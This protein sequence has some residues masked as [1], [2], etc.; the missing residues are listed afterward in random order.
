MKVLWTGAVVV[1]A[2]LLSPAAAINF[3]S[4]KYYVS[5]CWHTV[6]AADNAC[7]AGASAIGSSCLDLACLD[8]GVCW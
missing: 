6:P 4:P 5:Q 2:V 3:Y 8:T 7:T 1:L